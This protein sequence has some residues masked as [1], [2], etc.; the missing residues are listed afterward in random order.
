MP[1]ELIRQFEDERDLE[2]LAAIDAGESFLD[3]AERFSVS[4]DHV[5]ALWEA[6]CACDQDGDGHGIAPLLILPLAI[7]AWAPIAWPLWQ[8]FHG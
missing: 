1:G 5:Q 7:L 8:V 3:I 6:M 4:E 2:I